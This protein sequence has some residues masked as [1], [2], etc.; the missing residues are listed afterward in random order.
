[1]AKRG[2]GATTPSQEMAARVRTVR[3]RKGWTSQQKLADELGKLG[4]EVDRSA[5]AR[6][7]TGKRGVHVDEA[8]AL[9]A[10]LEVSPLSLML[11]SAPGE[12]VAVAPE[13]TVT[14]AEARAWARGESPLPGQDQRFFEQEA[15]EF[16]VE[17]GALQRVPG[18]YGAVDRLAEALQADDRKAALRALAVLEAEV[19]RQRKN[20]PR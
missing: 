1:M 4:Y 13:M 19:A 3:I 2:A 7:E 17:V 8:F 12:P 5:I 14:S 18:L 6:L 10:A 11:P 9:A 15:P 16:W 20:L